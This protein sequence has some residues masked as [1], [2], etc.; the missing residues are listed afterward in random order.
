MNLE[1]ELKF[2]INSQQVESLM[3]LVG[4]CSFTDETHLDQ[5]FNHPSR[6]FRQTD[7][8]VRIRSLNG[9]NY[10][11]YKGPVQ[12]TVAKTR[13]EIEVPFES[14]SE[15]ADQ[16][17]ELLTQL[18]FRA[19]REV[20]KSRRSFS[21]NFDEHDFTLALDD[22]PPLGQFLEIELIADSADRDAAEAAVW[23][24]ARSIGLTT[25]ETRSYLDMM[26]ELDSK[27]R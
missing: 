14:G 25:P 1:V 10:L 16:L 4:R 2:R 27:S 6:D 5:Y 23:K 7:E 3:K 8:A 22:V 12:G 13:H 20:R 9:S 11:T 26:I 18:S 17:R 24:L 21:V 15:S 19:V